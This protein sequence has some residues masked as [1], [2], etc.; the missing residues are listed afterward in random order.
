MKGADVATAPARLFVAPVASRGE[1]GRDILT[2]GY[3]YTNL[4]A[5]VSYT[6]SIEM[7]LFLIVIF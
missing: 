4:L 6:F 5:M 2:S 1:G 3:R 7:I